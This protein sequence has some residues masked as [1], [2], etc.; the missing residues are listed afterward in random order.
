MKTMPWLSDCSSGRIF[1]WL[2]L[3]RLSPFPGS[4]PDLANLLVSII[5]FGRSIVGV[6]M[7]QTGAK[8]NQT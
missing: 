2:I 8:V 7:P 6:I 5:A 4:L 1:N 3:P